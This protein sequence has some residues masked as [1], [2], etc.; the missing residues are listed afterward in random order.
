MKRK[1]KWV[2][3]KKIKEQFLNLFSNVNKKISTKKPKTE[4]KKTKFYFK[5]MPVKI[6]TN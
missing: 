1:S 3:N 4:S 5:K 2:S 6:S